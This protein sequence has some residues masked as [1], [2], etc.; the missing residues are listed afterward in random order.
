MKPNLTPYQFRISGG[1]K[2]T[3]FVIAATVMS[4]LIR[5]ALLEVIAGEN[6]VRESLPPS[7]VPTWVAV[8][9][10]CIVDGSSTLIYK[11]FRTNNVELIR[12][13][14]TATGK[15]ADF[16]VPSKARNPM[17][18]KPGIVVPCTDGTILVYS[19]D[20]NEIFRQRI[21][22]TTILSCVR[23]SAHEFAILGS[24]WLD[25]KKDFELSVKVVRFTGTKLAVRVLGTVSHPGLLVSPDERTLWWLRD[26]DSR[27]FSLSRSN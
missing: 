1:G 14:E 9:G 6:D 3:R 22:S 8:T 23:I 26:A 18:M 27:H 5:V 4:L 17:L 12:V 11:I 15:A 10:D 19:L 7:T 24:W 2:Y 13:V 21:P 20:R 25:E 16:Q